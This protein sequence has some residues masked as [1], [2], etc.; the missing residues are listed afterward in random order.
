MKTEQ[1]LTATLIKWS[2]QTDPKRIEAWLE[3][4]KEAG[5]IESART[6]KYDPNITYPILYLV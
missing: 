1:H 5:H 2:D 6:E 3:K 4:L